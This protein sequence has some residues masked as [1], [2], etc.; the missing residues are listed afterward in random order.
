MDAPAAGEAGELSDR[1]EACA[2]ASTSG[3]ASPPPC[4]L[5]THSVSK[6]HNI[7]TLVRCA[8]AF[9][10][11]EAAGRPRRKAAHTAIL[12]TPQQSC[13]PPG[14]GS[15]RGHQQRCHRAISAGSSC[16]CDYGTAAAATTPALTLRSSGGG[17]GCA[18]ETN[19]LIRGG[20]VPMA[21]GRSQSARVQA[22]T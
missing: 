6:K 9:G 5:V 15:P 18:M 17:S 20:S 8:T 1:A 12:Q 19:D 10:V 22:A 7:G 3:S 11:K 4:F 13:R 16:G 14:D 2:E 21:Q